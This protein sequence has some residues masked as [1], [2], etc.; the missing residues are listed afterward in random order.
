MFNPAFVNFLPHIGG[1]LILLL[2]IFTAGHVVIFKRDSRAAVGWIGI[3][4]II[5][6]IGSILYVIFGINRIKRKAIRKRRNITKFGRQTTPFLCTIEYLKDFLPEQRTNLVR[7]GKVSNQVT[8]HSLL[9]GNSIVPLL[10]GDNVYPKILEAINCAQR[11]ISL[12]TYIFNND[13]VGDMFIDAL[14]AAV[15]RGVDVRV[16]IDDVGAH[17]TF[18]SV[19]KKLRL[20]GIKT[21]VFMPTIVPW[22]ISSINLRNHKKIIVID[23]ITGFTGSMNIQEGNVLKDN[24][25]EP[26]KDLHFKITGPIVRQLQRTFVEDWSFA[27]KEILTGEKWFPDIK[28]DGTIIARAINDGPDEDFIK[29][30]KIILGAL[31]CAEDSVRIVTP[32]FLPELELISAINSALMRGVKVDVVLPEK[33]NHRIV[34]W[35]SMAQLWQMLQWGCKVWMNPPPFDHSKLMVVDNAWSLI[36]S[37]NWDPRSLRLNFEFNVESYSQDLAKELNIIIDEKI[38]KSRL[39]TIEEVN[40][41]PLAIKLRDGFSRLFTPYL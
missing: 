2:T 6:L 24:P 8:R 31:A 32:Y 28:E 17:H 1:F 20:Q 3:I 35:A 27:S 26:I 15:K 39:I 5:P 21:K 38:K 14:S 16:L 23:G 13:I 7:L 25:R 29:Q 9:C 36:G 10:Y 4:L 40:N 34:S 30:L 37:A 41:R 18:P 11:S 19:V 22:W 12:A 33:N